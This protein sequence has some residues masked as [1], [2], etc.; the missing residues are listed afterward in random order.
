MDKLLNFF[1]YENIEGSTLIN[2]NLHNVEIENL[3]SIEYKHKLSLFHNF[4]IPKVIVKDNIIEFYTSDNMK[5]ESK[6]YH[7]EDV[8]SF[9][10]NVCKFDNDDLLV[11]TRINYATDN[12]L[13]KNIANFQYYSI[14]EISYEK[15]FCFKNGLCNNT[16][17]HL[18]HMKSIQG[19]I[20]GYCTQYTLYNCTYQDKHYNT[21]QVCS[22]CSLLRV[23]NTIYS[24]YLNSK[25][26]DDNVVNYDYE[27]KPFYEHF[28]LGYEPG[29]WSNGDIEDLERISYKIGIEIVQSFQTDNGKILKK[30]D[31]VLNYYFDYKTSEAIFDEKYGK[32]RFYIHVGKKL[33]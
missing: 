12:H 15:C 2:V 26:K 29:Y 11:L 30:G 31:S 5:K 13:L 10:Y 21:I 20:F 28:A 22:D 14:K 7:L 3:Y 17:R 25:Q 23:D 1:E 27:P 6:W 33:Q 24:L 8:Y 16:R 19:Y 9:R 4:I 32:T 18:N